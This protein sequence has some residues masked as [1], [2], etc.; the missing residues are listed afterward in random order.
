MRSS[1]TMYMNL[2]CL[3]RQLEFLEYLALFNW[4]CQ[5]PSFRPTTEITFLP[6][7]HLLLRWLVSKC[8]NIPV[9]LSPLGLNASVNLC[10]YFYNDQ[11]P[12]PVHESV[13]LY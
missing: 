5:F 11:V 2:E 4:I 13:H 12:H 9:L 3:Q 10:L 6:I 8:D 1:A 7:T